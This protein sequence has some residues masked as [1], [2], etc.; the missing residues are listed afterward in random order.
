MLHLKI[1]SLLLNLLQ[2]GGEK[3]AAI[4]CRFLPSNNDY[5]Y[6]KWDVL[7]F[8]SP[9]VENDKKL[10]FQPLQHIGCKVVRELLWGFL[11]FKLSIVA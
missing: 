6:F 4:G 1:Q 10:Q 3:A 7:F 11:L 8:G 2:K 9:L 5:H